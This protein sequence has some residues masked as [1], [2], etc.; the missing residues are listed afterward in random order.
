MGSSFYRNSEACILVFD[1]TENESFQNIDIWRQ[2]FL[3]QLNPTDPNAFPFIMLGNKSDLKNDMK[4]KQEDIDN[5]CTEHNNMP[6]FMTSA[7]DNINLEE[8]FNKVMEMVLERYNKN[9][10][11]FVPVGNLKLGKEEKKKK[12][13]C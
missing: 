1:I 3:D 13:C 9:D 11:N 7:K 4:V 5:Y 6:F 8:T 12:K 10:E 2:E